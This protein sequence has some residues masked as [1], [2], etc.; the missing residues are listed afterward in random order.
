[1]RLSG[2]PEEIGQW[3]GE[4]PAAEIQIVVCEYIAES[5]TW[6]FGR[7]KMMARVRQIPHPDRVTEPAS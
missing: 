6:R 3:H 7:D 1:V 2:V 4:L 5:F